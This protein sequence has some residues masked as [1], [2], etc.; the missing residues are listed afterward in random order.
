MQ[1]SDKLIFLIIIFI[2]YRFAFAIQP[3]E[4][5]VLYN[6]DWR[7]DLPG[8]NPGQDSLEVAQYYVSRHTD[9]KT[10]KKPYLLGLHCVPT[11]QRSN[12]LTCNLQLSNL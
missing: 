7:E 3:D 9:P 5:L 2:F 4:V 12:V 10:G 6:A 11:C 1:L 8:S